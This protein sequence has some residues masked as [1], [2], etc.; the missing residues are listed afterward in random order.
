MR[1]CPTHQ[2]FPFFRIFVTLFTTFNLLSTSS[3]VFYPFYFFF[4]PFSK[5]YSFFFLMVHVSDPFI[6]TLRIRLIEN[7][8]LRLMGIFLA[9]SN[10][11]TFPEPSLPVVILLRTFTVQ[12]PFNVVKLSRFLK[13]LTSSSAFPCTDMLKWLF[14]FPLCLTFVFSVFILIPKFLLCS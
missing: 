11:L 12:F 2:F 3:F 14:S 5:Y 9:V 8:F 1:I 7:L 4:P 13:D 10:Q 6:I